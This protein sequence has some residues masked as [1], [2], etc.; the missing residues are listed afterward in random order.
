MAVLSVTTEHDGLLGVLAP[1]AIGAAAG[2]ALVVDVDGA[3]V[4]FPAPITL[5]ELVDRGP[6]RQDLTPTRTGL[7]VLANGGITEADAGPVLDALS[8]SWPAVVFRRHS[9]SAADVVVRPLLPG[10]GPHEGGGSSADVPAPDVRAAHTVYQ[11]T[12][13][14]GRAPAGALVVRRPPR[15]AVA[16]LLAGRDPGRS[17]WI[18]DW[19]AVWRFA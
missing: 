9:A 17:R 14:G 4:P 15:Q 8:Q 11:A 16:R 19:T 6:T 3:G 2:T 13:L 18:R 10:F 5:A 1:L 7:A 12:G